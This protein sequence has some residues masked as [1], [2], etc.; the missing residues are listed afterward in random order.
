MASGFGSEEMT[1]A[2]K[3]SYT[4]QIKWQKQ[5]KENRKKRLK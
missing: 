5:Q 3:N 4:W 1:A 2:Q